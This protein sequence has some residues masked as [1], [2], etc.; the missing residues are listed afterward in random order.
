MTKKTQT[1]L[2]MLAIVAIIIAFDIFVAIDKFDN[3]TISAV[4]AK[5][6]I[7][8]A[9]LPVAWGALT[10]HFL[11][12]RTKK[13]YRKYSILKDPNSNKRYFY[14]AGTCGLILVLSL[15]G[16]MPS[17]NPFIYFIFGAGIG[18]EFWPQFKEVVDD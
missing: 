6:S 1:G 7:H 2:A 14:L 10:A 15:F 11:A 12:H 9:F 8:Y 18:Y 5:L 3:N 4:F 16:G 13:Q 17:I